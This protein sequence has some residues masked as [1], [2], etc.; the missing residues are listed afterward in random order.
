MHMTES[1]SLMALYRIQAVPAFV[2]NQQYK[3][4]LQMAKTI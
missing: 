3:T 4:D 1:Q 2:V